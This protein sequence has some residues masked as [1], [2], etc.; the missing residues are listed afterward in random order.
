MTLVEFFSIAKMAATNFLELGVDAL[1]LPIF[2]PIILWLI[3][4]AKF[5]N[6]PN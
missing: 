1:Q 4:Y 3:I 5:L 2:I 6:S